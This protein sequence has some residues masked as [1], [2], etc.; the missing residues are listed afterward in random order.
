MT[1]S[2]T[3]AKGFTLASAGLLAGAVLVGLLAVFG[4]DV[5]GSSILDVPVFVLG[6]AWLLLPPATCLAGILL[7]WRARASRLLAVNAGVLVLWAGST[8]YL[9]TLSG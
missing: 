2:T 7:S 4:A 9:M 5:S 3:L 1:G 8:T 6:W